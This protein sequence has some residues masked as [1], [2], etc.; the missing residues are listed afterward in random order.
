METSGC[1][2]SGFWFRVQRERAT[3]EHT[4]EFQT[5]RFTLKLFPGT[6]ETSVRRQW[7][8]ISKTFDVYPGRELTVLA[9]GEVT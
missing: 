7:A 1:M 6:D 8:P 5:Q 4:R 3:P 2:V 9:D